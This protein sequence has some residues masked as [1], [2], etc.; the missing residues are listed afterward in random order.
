MVVRSA[1]DFATAVIK[2]IFTL[3]V[4]YSAVQV[5]SLISNADAELNKVASIFA[6]LFLIL[7]L[8]YYGTYGSRKLMKSMTY[9]GDIGCS[10]TIHSFYN[11]GFVMSKV[12]FPLIRQG[13]HYGMLFFFIR[14]AS[15]KD[16]E[17]IESDYV[18]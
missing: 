13:L 7:S 12:L 8:T 6:R 1:I 10:D 2:S 3:Y 15:S 4:Y 17:N 16:S 9:A 18:E 11:I 5:I 14:L